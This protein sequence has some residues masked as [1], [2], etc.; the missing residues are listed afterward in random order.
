MFGEEYKL[1]CIAYKSNLVTFTAEGFN[2]IHLNQVDSEEPAV[3]AWNLRAISASCI[4]KEYS[5][6]RNCG[7]NLSENVHLK[8]RIEN[9]L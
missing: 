5:Y 2:L 1:N 3:A 7:A 4:N 9:G 6:V 8:V